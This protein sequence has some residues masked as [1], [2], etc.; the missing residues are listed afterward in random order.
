MH[1]LRETQ[2]LLL[3]PQ[4][5]LKPMS[6]ALVL[7]IRVHLQYLGHPIANDNLYCSPSMQE[8]AGVGQPGDQGRTSGVPSD[9]HASA[10]HAR[11]ELDGQ[12]AHSRS[13]GQDA[14]LKCNGQDAAE[15]EM[16]AGT[17]SCSAPSGQPP[18]RRDNGSDTEMKDSAAPPHVEEAGVEG[19]TAALQCGCC[20]G[21]GRASSGEE[22]AALRDLGCSIWEGQGVS[23]DPLCS[24][25][26]NIA[27]PPA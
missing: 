27:A 22:C 11:G 17:A 21:G 16:Q 14:H 10:S 26:P 12:D 19:G 1:L 15:S 23:T 8:A 9:S 6:C 24:N 5:L 3:R 20:E 18:E 13:N 2:Q 4:G 7:Q 25:C